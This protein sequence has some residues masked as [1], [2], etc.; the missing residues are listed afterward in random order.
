MLSSFNSLKKKYGL[1]VTKIGPE[2]H[3]KKVGLKYAGLK[4]WA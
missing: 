3:V 1:N 2:R 4:D